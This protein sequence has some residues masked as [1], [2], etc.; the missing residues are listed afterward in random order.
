MRSCGFGASWGLNAV[1]GSGLASH[2]VNDIP[3]GTPG[4]FISATVVRKVSEWCDQVNL[5]KEG[6]MLWAREPRHYRQTH[7]LVGSSVSFINMETAVKAR[8]VE[9]ANEMSKMR[10]TMHV[11]TVL[12]GDSS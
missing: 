6:V 11:L 7:A 8:V 2:R 12:G 5:I 9:A 1:Y 3:G 10:N 4:S